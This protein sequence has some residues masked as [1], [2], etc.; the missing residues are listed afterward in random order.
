M[1]QKWMHKSIICGLF[2]IYLIVGIFLY[3]DYGIS[4][5]ERDERESAFVNIKYALDT[6]GVDALDG[7][8]GDLE[9]YDYRY[10]GIA[11][12][13]VPSVLEWMKGFPGKHWSQW[14]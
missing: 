12:Q 7:A 4:T 5:D 6:L 1:K 14:D 10:Y 13:V 8:N 3:K 11:M 2:M 9:K